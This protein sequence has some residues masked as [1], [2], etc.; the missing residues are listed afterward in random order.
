MKTDTIREIRQWIKLA[1]KVFSELKG[2]VKDGS[3]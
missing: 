3:K 1:I 2:V